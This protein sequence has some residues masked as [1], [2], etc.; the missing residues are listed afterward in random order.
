M[1]RI[2]VIGV[3]SGVGKSTFARRL[4]E[5]IGIEVTHLD[6]L[7]WKP[8][9]VEASI[10]E[11]SEAQQNSVHNEKWIIEGNYNATASIR[12]P[13][14]DTIIYLELPLY[15]CLYRVL[16]RRVQFHG[17]TRNDVGEGCKEKVDWAFLKFII[18]TYG[19]R[20]KKMIERLQYYVDEG[21][22][23]HYLKTPKQIEGFLKTIAKKYK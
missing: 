13:H 5:L 3:A 7:F 1:N 16:K 18:T 2:M 22:T 11:F 8:N 21:K 23:V 20:K 17:K 4:G 10:E 15:V 14:A 19:P 12:E 9:W 6:R